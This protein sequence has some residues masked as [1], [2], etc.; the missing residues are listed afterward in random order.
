VGG[1]GGSYS[2]SVLV[3]DACILVLVGASSAIVG[4][5]IWGDWD[6]MQ[7]KT[8]LLLA[9]LYAFI[10]FFLSNGVAVRLPPPYVSVEVAGSAGG[11]RG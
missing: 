3:I 1:G 11:R 9:H 4:Y 8:T 2:Y 5:M 10:T 6:S 7:A